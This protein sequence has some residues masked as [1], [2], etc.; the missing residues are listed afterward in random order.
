MTFFIKRPTAVAGIPSDLN[1]NSVTA[2][3]ISV[4]N[5]RPKT[6]SIL[7][8]DFTG[9][10]I[11]SGLIDLGLPDRRFIHFF[12]RTGD[13]DVSVNTRALST[14]FISPRSQSAIGF[15]CGIF[16]NND[17]QFSLGTPD[18]RWSAIYTFRTITGELVSVTNDNIYVRNTL[19][20]IVSGVSLG[21]SDKYFGWVW[22]DTLWTR[23]IGS[24]T[25]N[26]VYLRNPIVPFSPG[27]TGLG[28]AD[29]PLGRSFF[30]EVRTDWLVADLLLAKDGYMIKTRN[31][32]IPETD[33]VGN[34][35]SPDKRFN[36]GYIYDLS[37]DV[38]R[39]INGSSIS[40]RNDIIPETDNA[41]NL[42]TPDKRFAKIYAVEVYTGDIKLKNGWIITEKDDNGNIID[43]VRILNSKGEEI[44]RIT[45]DGIYFKG[46]KLKLEFEQ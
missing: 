42:G 21:T 1:V 7:T 38:L 6:Y 29:N 2:N 41:I 14:D 3:V 19:I 10:I 20:P 13:F 4:D 44:F 22:M 12:A 35:G 11:P 15:Y 8:F 25:F 32:I 24:R 36:S 27:S 46:K 28:T 37:I 40:L 23:E 9:N 39:A 17:N 16:P 18:L 34:L 30:T 26:Y 43:G 33:L 31:D 5:I 45:E